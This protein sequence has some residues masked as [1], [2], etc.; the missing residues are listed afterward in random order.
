M[1]RPSTQNSPDT[2]GTTPRGARGVFV[3]LLGVL[4]L[5]GFLFWTVFGETGKQPTLLAPRLET[6]TTEEPIDTGPT[7]VVADSVPLP[8]DN[9]S[10]DTEPPRASGPDS[11][12]RQSGTLLGSV[13]IPEALRGRVAIWTLEVAEARNDADS[14]VVKGARQFRRRFEVRSGAGIAR[15]RVDDVP[16][17]DYG[18]YVAATCLEPPAASPSTLVTLDARRPESEV[19]LSLAVAP[20]LHVT[21][22]D[23]EMAALREVRVTIRPIGFPAGRSLGTVLTDIYGLAIFSSVAIGEYELVI[24][25]VARPVVPVRRISIDSK[26]LQFE[27]VTVPK[28]GNLTL[29]L[30][31]PAGGGVDQAEVV[32]IAKDTK[33]YKKYETKTDVS[34]RANLEHL[35]P[36]PYYLHLTKSGFERRFEKIVVTENETT[37]KRVTMH[38]DFRRGR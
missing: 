16:F 12:Q 23:Q 11:P 20:S 18:W 14:R 19:T 32:A 13:L 9:G 37:E 21:V 29:L 2:A 4:A 24:G 8:F 27:R 34:G 30:A 10:S 25:P 31:T 26:Q 7:A 6:N 33:I 1:P 36:G 3:L 22:K 35:P 38:W 28:G 17:S 15:F 5:S